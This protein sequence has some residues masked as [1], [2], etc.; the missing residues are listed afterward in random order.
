ML[1]L[2]AF[3]LP[4]ALCG[5]VRGQ[6]NDGAPAGFADR[7]SADESAQDQES[8]GQ[9]QDEG[10][11]DGAA[12]DRLL[13]AGHPGVEKFVESMRSSDPEEWIRGLA[14]LSAHFGADSPAWVADVLHVYLGGA[15]AAQH[16]TRTRKLLADPVIETRNPCEAIL[17]DLLGRP[18]PSPILEAVQ[19]AVSRIAA[20]PQRRMQLLARLERDAGA[21][22]TLFRR[23]FRTLS[24]H[25]PSATVHLAMRRLGATAGSEPAAQTPDP[26][27]AAIV[28][29]LQELFVDPH[30][31]PSWWR[32]WWVVNRH[33]PIA[34]YLAEQ[35]RNGAMDD[36][37]EFLQRSL[38]P[39]RSQP[40]AYRE[41]VLDMLSRPAEFQRLALQEVPRL[42]EGATVEELMP[43]ADRLLEL[44][45]EPEPSS[46]ARTPARRG[47]GNRQDLQLGAL[48]ALRHLPSSGFQD[49]EPLLE[50]LSRW[51]GAIPTWT[52]EAR[53]L[54][55]LRLGTTALEVAGALGARVP[56]AIE[57]GIQRQLENA[58][59]EPA[60]WPAE[61]DALITQ[62]LRELARVG[63]RPESL[64]LLERLFLSDRLV[65]TDREEARRQVHELAVQVVGT[66][67]HLLASEEQR[68]A[69]FEFLEQALSREHAG[70]VRFWA[71]AG[72]ANL[73]DAAGIAPL[74][75]VVLQESGGNHKAEA[76]SAIS[77][78]GGLPAVSQ[79]RE[80]YQSLNSETQAGLRQ[81]VF[82][83]L[84]TLCLLGDDRLASLEEFLLPRTATGATERPQWFDD[85][86]A[87]AELM[88]RLDPEQLPELLESPELYGRWVRIRGEISNV[89]AARAQA[90]ADEAALLPAYAAVR[91]ATTVVLK[92]VDPASNLFQEID[93]K[94][95][96]QLRR[97]EL[98]GERTVLLEHLGKDSYAECMKALRDLL[99][100]ETD[101]RS[102]DDGPD[103]RPAHFEWFLQRVEKRESIPTDFVQ[104]LSELPG[105]FEFQLGEAAQ[106][107]LDQL[108]QRADA[109]VESHSDAIAPGTPK[110]VPGGSRK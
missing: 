13:P 84:R 32:Q 87:D 89:M 28:G 101:R 64:P 103:P 21:S 9:P 23:L 25:D 93:P 96:A 63:A 12:A 38:E 30:D 108:T 109:V 5:G 51:I 22:D 107:Q 95:V 62:F 99:Q 83:K 6:G 78:I 4:F 24:A 50:S 66:K 85:C 36:V 37:V 100:R 19:A 47:S 74:V 48:S 41:A 68:R 34:E 27:T 106:T 56:R 44:A 76:V 39:L 71:I 2:C 98:L 33:R 49:Y 29:A 17:I 92:R 15:E 88:Q 80:L 59:G 79:L 45:K 70:Q 52:S 40:K 46:A 20:N 77:R 81:E 11:A 105:T 86:I 110:V 94:L 3:L 7:E 55:E 1:F 58:S 10:A 65:G 67:P 16:L 90:V 57:D 61:R 42:V 60:T 91:K 18:N 72:L 104:G 97:N 8:G 102:L 53:D 75:A 35:S 82:Q 14:R 26:Q 69:V 43:F 73:K 54:R 31:D